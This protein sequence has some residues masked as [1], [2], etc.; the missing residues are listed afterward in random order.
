VYPRAGLDDLEKLKSFYP[1][2]DSNSD[3]LD[4]QSVGSRYT[5]YA[6]AGHKLN[7]FHLNN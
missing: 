4:I 7:I 6:T 2:R 5:D 3:L 1:Y